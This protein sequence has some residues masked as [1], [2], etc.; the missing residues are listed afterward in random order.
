MSRPTDERCRE[1][2]EYDRPPEIKIGRLRPRP[3]TAVSRK[4]PTVAISA[5]YLRISVMGAGPA[6]CFNV[7]ANVR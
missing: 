7:I 5:A 4:L 6:F 3:T 2:R 1:N